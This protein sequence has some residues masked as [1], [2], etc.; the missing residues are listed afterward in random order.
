MQTV[1][2]FEVAMKFTPSFV[3]GLASGDRR[4]VQTCLRGKNW[5]T[6]DAETE[7]NCQ[8]KNNIENTKQ[9][10]NFTAFFI[11]FRSIFSSY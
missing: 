1:K 3:G 9:N 11:T 2:T 4:I 7:S 6:I 8:T 10:Q 5:Q